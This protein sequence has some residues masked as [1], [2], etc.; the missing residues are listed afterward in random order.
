MNKKVYKKHKKDF[1]PFFALVVCVE[2]NSIQLKWP[3][4]RFSAFFSVSSEFDS[5]LEK[6]EK[7]FFLLL[8]R[9]GRREIQEIREFFRTADYELGLGQFLIG[10]SR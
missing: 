1:L 6:T 9:K 8:D 3:T 2:T 5:W 4:L 7:K 10:D